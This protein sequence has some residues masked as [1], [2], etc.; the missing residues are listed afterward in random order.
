M[1]RADRNQL[2]RLRSTPRSTPHDLD[3][4]LVDDVLGQRRE[5]SIFTDPEH[6][7]SLQATHVVLSDDAL[8]RLITRHRRWRAGFL[9]CVYE[10]RLR[11]IVGSFRRGLRQHLTHKRTNTIAGIVLH[12]TVLVSNS[13]TRVSASFPLRKVK[14]TRPT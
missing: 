1:I 9:N 14:S 13:R 5:S 2:R 4:L 11:L 7:T 3:L 8:R 10:T 12:Q 6:F